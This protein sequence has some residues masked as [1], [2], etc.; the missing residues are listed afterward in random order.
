[1]VSRYMH[2]PGKDHWLTV[3]WILQ[4]LYET[5]DFGLLVKKNYGQQCAGY[6]DSDFA[7]DLDRRI[8]TMGYV[9]TLG[10]GSVS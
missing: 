4:Y 8:S 3:K 2:N 9:F 7:G 5:V 6:C 1:M 10:G